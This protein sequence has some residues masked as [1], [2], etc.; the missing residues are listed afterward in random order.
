[1]NILII[2]MKKKM[3][4]LEHRE[5]RIL[6]RDKQTRA[7]A[8]WYACFSAAAAVLQLVYPEKGFHSVSPVLTVAL[9]LLTIC[10]CMQKGAE[11]A[12][13]LRGRKARL[14]RLIYEAERTEDADLGRLQAEYLEVCACDEGINSHDRRSILRMHDLEEQSSEKK[15]RGYEKFLYWFVEIAGMVLKT[16]VLLAPA[17]AIALAAI[18][19]L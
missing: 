2:D 1:M 12:G 17:A 5:E 6:S 13:Q 3:R 14:Q 10:V 11:R 9:A 8:V 19:L 16:I 7:L 15:L 18:R 4:E